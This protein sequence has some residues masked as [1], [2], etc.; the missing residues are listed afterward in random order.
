MKSINMHCAS[1]ALVLVRMWESR[2]V[3]RIFMRGVLS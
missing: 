2:G 3:A 1:V